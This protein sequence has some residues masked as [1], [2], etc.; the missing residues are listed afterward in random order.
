MHEAGHAA[1][2]KL[3]EASVVEIELYPDTVRPHGRCRIERTDQQR[4]VIALG[5]FA[6]ERRLW[7]DKRLVDAKGELLLEPAMLQ[8]AAINADED[9][10]SFFGADLR[11]PDGYWPREKDMLFMTSARDLGLMLD[12]KLVEKLATAL[13]NH[14]KLDE[15]TVA[16]ILGEAP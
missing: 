14:H 4:P 3:V 7:E 16:A 11:K 1:A 9:R 10:L 8:A 15:R 2:A 5:G 12:M 13:L 6:V